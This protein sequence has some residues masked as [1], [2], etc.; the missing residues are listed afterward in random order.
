MVYSIEKEWI[1]KECPVK[2]IC[3]FSFHKFIRGALF[4]AQNQVLFQSKTHPVKSKTKHMIG[5]SLMVMGGLFILSGFFIYKSS[6]T[7]DPVLAK[8]IS[9]TSNFVDK[10]EAN[11]DQ[12][13]EEL[14]SLIELAKADGVL[15]QNEKR[16]LSKKARECQLNPGKILNNIE[17]ELKEN[18]TTPETEIVNQTK[19]KGDDFEKFIVQKFSKKYYKVKEWAGDKY[20]K[21]VYAETTIQ[22][23]L[24]LELE[25]GNIS[26]EFSVECKWRRIF[27]KGGLEFASEKQ[28][29]NYKSFQKKKDIPVFIAI[30]VHGEPS[31]PEQLYVVPLEEI[32]SNFIAMGQLKK[33]R[34]HTKSNFFFD[35]KTHVLK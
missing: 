11:H 10:V 5:I 31:S 19:K 16:I 27:D 12:A 15:T 9:L 25:L 2:F 23:D 35:S 28:L 33:Y 18:S 3:T 14:N 22:P 30:G 6:L 17:L 29:E 7:A 4:S 24:V 8:N 26:Q 20:V 1:N 32:E 34:K 13:K 21:G